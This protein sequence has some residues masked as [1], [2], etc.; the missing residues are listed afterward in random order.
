MQ[1]Y[2]ETSYQLIQY[3]HK[4]SAYTGVIQC[5]LKY[6]LTFAKKRGYN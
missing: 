6:T 2:D 1:K 4:N 5:V 3:R